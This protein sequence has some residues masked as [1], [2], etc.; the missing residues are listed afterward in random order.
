MANTGYR[1]QY[2]QEQSGSNDPFWILFCVIAAI[3][4]ALAGLPWIVIGFVA[5]RYLQR[6]LHWRLSFLLW[7][8]W[9]FLAAFTIYHSYQ[10]SLEPLFQRELTDYF[11]AGERYHWDILSY[12]LRQLW[13]ETWPVWLYTWPGIGIAGFVGELY[14]NR[15]D[16]VRTLRQ[17]E[18]RRQRRAQR[19]QHQARKRTSRPAH[20]PDEVGGLMVIGVPIRDDEEE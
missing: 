13:A 10:H 12:P 9:L 19:F 1:R 3:A 16:T 6:W 20:I 14:A 17:N 11:H 5:Q 2:Q 18:Q 7:L 4:L 15:N 8:V